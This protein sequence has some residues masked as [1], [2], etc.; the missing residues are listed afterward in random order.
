VGGAHIR[1]YIIQG[2]FSGSGGKDSK[3]W[4]GG[5]NDLLRAQAKAGKYR[6]SAYANEAY[7]FV[8]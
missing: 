4:K 3:I 8:L 7:K 1:V 2:D 6:S 5:K